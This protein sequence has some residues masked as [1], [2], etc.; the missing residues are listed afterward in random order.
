[1][2][3]NNLKMDRKLQVLFGV[4]WWYTKWSTELIPRNEVKYTFF[5]FVDRL[6]SGSWFR[7]TM[8]AYLFS[9]LNYALLADLN[10]LSC[11]GSFE[12]VAC[13]T[14]FMDTAMIVCMPLS[15]SPIFTECDSAMPKW[16]LE[17]RYLVF[18]LVFWCASR[19]I[20][21]NRRCPFH[22]AWK[23]RD[24]LPFNHDLFQ[25]QSRSKLGQ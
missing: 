9:K 23:W 25:W 17:P 20:S 5:N 1:M 4:E 13:S 11:W 2:R 14:G 3:L 21:N 8:I 6:M 7:S 18:V 12:Q 24:M 10:V 19:M 15:L 22:W 16:S